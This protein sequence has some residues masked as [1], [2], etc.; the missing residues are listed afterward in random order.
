[1]SEEIFSISKDRIRAKDLLDMAQERIRDIISILPRD[2]AYKIIEEYYEVLVQLMTS[3][4]YLDG[5]KTLSHVALIEYISNNY[6]QINENEIKLIDDLRKF[7]HGTFYYGKKIT[8]VFLIN[9]EEDINRI[10]NKFIA[11]IE[12]KL[13]LEKK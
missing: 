12:D 6:K 7:R 11:L 3:I 13:N 1:M 9:R 10:I 4:M 8:N 5:N 2:K